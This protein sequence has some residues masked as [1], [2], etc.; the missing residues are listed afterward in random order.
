MSAPNISSF[1]RGIA[2]DALRD[3]YVRGKKASCGSANDPCRNPG[4]PAKASQGGGWITPLVSIL[5]LDNHDLN[6]QVRTGGRVLIQGNA[7]LDV[8]SLSKSPPLER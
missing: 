5:M 1:I 8:K 4:P 7:W 3:V 2:E 6:I